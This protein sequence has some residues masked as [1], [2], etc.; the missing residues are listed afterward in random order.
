MQESKSFH[1]LGDNCLAI[2]ELTIM[3]NSFLEDYG[4]DHKDQTWYYF[5]RLNVPVR[6]RH[7]GI[8][9]KLLRETIDWAD[10][11]KINIILEINPYGDMSY[12][13]LEKLYM[14]FGFVK[15]EKC[16]IRYFREGGE[17]Y[18]RLTSQ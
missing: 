16:Y 18:P 2:C 3:D 5:N 8:A 10:W 4:F 13:D 14:K 7:R 9:A 1:Y 6:L 12:E 11:E 15:L 17:Y